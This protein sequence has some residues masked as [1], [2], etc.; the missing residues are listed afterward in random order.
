MKSVR[1]SVL[2]LVALLFLGAAGIASAD[3]V[4]GTINLQATG[5]NAN[6]TLTTSG[7]TSGTWTLTMDFVNKSGS[8]TDINSFSVQLFSSAGAETF[9]LTSETINGSSSLGN[10][11]FFANEKLNNGNTPDCKSGTVKG[12]VCG[13]TGQGTLHPFSVA[14]GT[15]TEFILSGTFSAPGGLISILDLMASGC[16]VA[17]TCKLDGGSNDGNKWAVS[18]TMGV[19]AAPEPSSFLCLVTGVSFLA[20]AFRRRLSSL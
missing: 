19:A 3:Q 14:S 4:S 16:T 6:G 10:W 2:A 15:T 11:E 13:D 8:T 20:L 5:W 1:L 18:G 17:G 9:S 12:W 7:T